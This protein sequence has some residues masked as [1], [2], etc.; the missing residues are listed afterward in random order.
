MAIIKKAIP[1][2]PD[3]RHDCFACCVKYSISEWEPVYT[4]GILTE[5]IVNCPFYKTNEEYKKGI[6]HERRNNEVHN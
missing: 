2:C 3:K 6:P 5:G 1:H 4:C